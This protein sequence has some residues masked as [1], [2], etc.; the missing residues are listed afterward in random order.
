MSEISIRHVKAQ[1]INDVY[2]LEKECFI[3]PWSIEVLLV[4][5][6]QSLYN[7]YF[8]V[9]KHGRIIG[10]AGINTVIDEAHIR[11]LCI[12]TCERH[13]G[14]GL[15]LLRYIENY[16]R[17]NGIKDLTLEVRRSNERA[18][19]LYESFGF[20]NEGIRPKYYDGI[21]DAIIMWKRDI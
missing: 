13:N 20:I 19:R 8:V 12:T 2:S 4:D 18:I 21:E 6:F 5:M 15:E 17:N 7:R 10:Y 11:K 3:T 16:C 14:Y 9:E 1:D